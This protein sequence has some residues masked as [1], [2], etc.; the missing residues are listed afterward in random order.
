MAEQRGWSRYLL[1]CLLLLIDRRLIGPPTLELVHDEALIARLI[2]NCHRMRCKFKIVFVYW[3]SLLA[4]HRIMSR[5]ML[6]AL[7]GTCLH[8]LLQHVQKSI[9]RTASSWIAFI[10]P[11]FLLSQIFLF[12]FIRQI[13]TAIICNHPDLHRFDIRQVLSTTPLTGPLA[14]TGFSYVSSR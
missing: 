7:W 4:E 11:S 10:V 1:I 9:R 12:I 14:A 8:G 2:I 5:H 6:H 3:H 13:I